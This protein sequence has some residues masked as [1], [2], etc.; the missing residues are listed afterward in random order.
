LQKARQ[1]R[2]WPADWQQ[3]CAVVRE[4][5]RMSAEVVELNRRPVTG[6]GRRT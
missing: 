6:C 1:C 3:G 2:R 4:H 5:H